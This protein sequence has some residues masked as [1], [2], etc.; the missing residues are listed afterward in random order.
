[1]NLAAFES[2]AS[3]WPVHYA[4]PVDPPAGLADK[5][6][7]KARRLAGLPGDFFFFSEARLR[8]V[9]EAVDAASRADAHLDFFHGFTPWIMSRP[10]RPYVAWSDCCFRDYVEIYH[11]RSSFAARDLARIEAAEAA[12]LNRAE[13]VL[14]TS[15]WAA[16]R[17]AEAYGL[18]RA[19]IG[20]VGIFG[21]AEAP[22]HDGYQG[23]SDFAF[24]STNFEAKGGPVVLAAFEAVRARRPQATLT[25]VGAAPLSPVD[26][27]GVRHLG[28][29]HKE[30]PSEAERLREVLA[31]ARALVLPTRS[32]IT[33]LLLV[34]AAYFG[35]PAVASRRF[36]IPE[37]V[38]D[39]VTGLLLDE[40][41][42]PVAV[43]AAMDAMLTSTDYPAMRSAAR[44]KAA[45]TLSKARF[46]DRLVGLV[47]DA[48]AS[49]GTVAA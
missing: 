46:R 15:R 49:T 27:P 1:M 43:A 31:G 44:R 13:R 7:S 22:E 41:S 38:E 4:G 21:E 12:W 8:R 5:A 26:R 42:D 47:G 3:A 2:L 14:F 33:P 9:A 36:A 16:D 45:E 23:G 48:L 24:I 29:L 6:V 19:R 28:F 39:G 25:I 10:Q 18:D 35:C 32:D 37:L 17:T 34:E 20:V 30:I 11:D 40:P